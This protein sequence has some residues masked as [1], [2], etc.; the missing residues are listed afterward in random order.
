MN[1]VIEVLRAPSPAARPQ[2]L[3]FDGEILWM[4][5]IDTQRIYAIDPL[6]WTVREEASAPGK[7]WGMTALGDEL[8]VL[9]GETAEDNRII[10]RYIPGHGF[11]TEYG[12]PCPDDT[13]SQLG[14][15]GEHLS[16]S[17]WYEKRILVLDERG[18]IVRTI[19]APRGICGQV[20]VDGAFHLL[21]T[22]DENSDNYFLTR[23][24]PETL[25]P[26]DLAR[27]PFGGRA[28]AYDGHKF[29]SN[30]RERNEIVAFSLPG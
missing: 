18:K 5:S 11:K 24:D 9:C 2:S 22:D 16:V 27:V 15:D 6:H 4:G 28:L 21:T 29:W 7:P 3:A 30:D 8:R 19:G 14:Y 25:G 20:I 13:G 26:T 1:D 23:I 17:Q 10:R 12:L